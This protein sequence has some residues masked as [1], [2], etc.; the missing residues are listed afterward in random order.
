MSGTKQWNLN[1][2]VVM[3]RQLH[4]IISIPVVCPPHSS[5]KNHRVYV[6][7]LRRCSFLSL[8]FLSG[9][10]VY[11]NDIF[12]KNSNKFFSTLYYWSLWVSV[13]NQSSK[14]KRRWH[15]AWEL[16][17]DGKIE[18]NFLN[19]ELGLHVH[20]SIKLHVTFQLSCLKF[21]FSSF[22]WVI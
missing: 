11:W 18:D 7:C 1:F 22:H 20:F 6:Y 13:Q 9:S 16:P 19:K 17:P 15:Y 12:I 14:N 8:S 4:K 5:W 3:L 10:S 2:F 21:A